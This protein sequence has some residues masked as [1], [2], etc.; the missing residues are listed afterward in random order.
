[1]ITITIPKN[2]VFW[3]II[4]WFISTLPDFLLGIA[5]L[6]M[7]WSKLIEWLS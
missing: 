3:M 6:I 4:V 7:D 2:L 1:M 5:Y